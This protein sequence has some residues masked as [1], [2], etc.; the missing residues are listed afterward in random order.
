MFRRRSKSSIKDDH[1]M[2]DSNSI[3]DDA[4]SIMNTVGSMSARSIGNLSSN[5]NVGSV[6]ESNNENNKSFEENDITS[7]TFD[8]GV[9]DTISNTIDKI[10]D[11]DNSSN[12]AISIGDNDSVHSKNDGLP[13]LNF[14]PNKKK[15][16][17]SEDRK[18][19]MVAEFIQEE[20]EKA[21][22][23]EEKKPGYLKGTVSTNADTRFESL[24][25][26]NHKRTYES[27]R[28]TKQEL[29]KSSSPM[30][31]ASAR[32]ENKNEVGMQL[33]VGPN[34]RIRE[35]RYR[36]KLMHVKV[37]LKAEMKLR[38]EFEEKVAFLEGK[39]IG[40]ELALS[41][42]RKKN[43]TNRIN[44]SDI[45]NTES[46]RAKKRDSTVNS[47]GMKADN[48]KDPRHVEVLKQRL[49][50][51]I[52]ESEK[53][54]LEV[55]EKNEELAKAQQV[56]KNLEHVI[57]SVKNNHTFKMFSDMK[58]K[59]DTSRKNTS[60][61]RSMGGV[62][63]KKA[64]AANEIKSKNKSRSPRDKRS[65]VG[66]KSM[67]PRR[68]RKSKSPRRR[69]AKKSK[70]PRRSSGKSPNV[71]ADHKSPNKND[72]RYTNNNRVR[73]SDKNNNLSY[74]IK[75][76]NSKSQDKLNRP[77]RNKDKNKI[78]GRS[79][80]F[81][82]QQRR[83]PSK[84]TNSLHRQR[85]QQEQQQG[86]KPSYAANNRRMSQQSFIDH[87]NKKRSPKIQQGQK[88]PRLKPVQ[89]QDEEH[90]VTVDTSKIKPM[91]GQM[92]G[93][94]AQQQKAAL[95]AHRRQFAQQQQQQKHQ[96][97]YN[98]TR[99]NIMENTVG[100]VNSN[101][102]HRSIG[103]TTNLGDDGTVVI[104]SNGNMMLPQSINAMAFG[105]QD[106]DLSDNN[107][108]GKEFEF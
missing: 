15:D 24:S 51:A 108:L 12:P 69:D 99:N 31:R 5:M 47:Q 103:G 81:Q 56:I 40:M 14:V 22:R 86:N 44:S 13:S 39:L 67:S 35:E 26:Q 25:E 73:N 90:F 36:E 6:I 66:G 48:A 79:T 60:K 21:K 74:H 63:S 50:D 11:D 27:F 4:S 61:N 75:S 65:A 78:N 84:S 52:Y 7:N 23:K 97:E 95:Q 76:N 101:D 54:R 106:G 58:R 100:S 59:G 20:V 91:V 9:N 93:K 30:K 16:I 42:E 34:A 82:H 83:S 96:M 33:K 2:N 10:N 55:R 19:E 85:Q 29:Q 18:N 1:A 43:S 17:S 64:N 89:H 37:E 68:G 70:S 104:T 45:N 77:Q 3:V 107:G 62:V 92:E 72:T 38:K 28:I 57:D 46:A 98:N 102:I 71:R 32:T 41:R 80:S 94:M 105:S 88:Y 87:Q 49:K 53:Q 8:F